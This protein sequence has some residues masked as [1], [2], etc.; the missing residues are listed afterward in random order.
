MDIY[1]DIII[2]TSQQWLFHL[3]FHSHWLS[4]FYPTWARLSS[5]TI[6]KS[7]FWRVFH[8]KTAISDVIVGSCIIISLLQYSIPKRPSA[9]NYF[10]P[11]PYLMCAYII[12]KQLSIAPLLLAY[13]DHHAS[14]LL[15]LCLNTLLKLYM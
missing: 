10:I 7:T 2:L 3:Q 11:F 13:Q 4:S 6:L 1:P 8:N 12:L 9:K 5:N 14:H 15:F